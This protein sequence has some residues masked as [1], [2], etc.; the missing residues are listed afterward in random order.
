MFTPHKV[1]CFCHCD[2]AT[3]RK[4][5]PVKGIW[6]R[7]KT[8]NEEH[9]VFTGGCTS[10][11]FRG[12]GESSYN[13]GEDDVWVLRRIDGCVQAPRTVIMHQRDGLPMVG[14]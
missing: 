9:L 14:V 1:T 11:D 10:W 12:S 2:C 4:K 5:N 7:R 8:L 13:G 6:E 3:E